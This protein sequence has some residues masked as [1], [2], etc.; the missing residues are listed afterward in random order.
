MATFIP[1]LTDVVPAPLLYQPDLQFALQAGMFANQQYNAALQQMSKIYGKYAAAPILNPEVDN[2]RKEYIDSL[3]KYIDKFKGVDLRNP[4]AISAFY[5]LFEPIAKDTEVMNGLRVTETYYQEKARIGVFKSRIGVVEGD[6]DKDGIKDYRIYNPEIEKYYDN[7][8][9]FYSQLKTGDPLL[10]S[11]SIKRGLVDIDHIKMTNDLF[12]DYLKA[13]GEKGAGGVETMIIDANGVIHNINEVKPGMVNRP[14]VVSA[15]GSVSTTI[16][17]QPVSQPQTGSPTSASSSAPIA[18]SGSSSASATAY[19][20]FAAYAVKTLGGEKQVIPLYKYFSDMVAQN[21]E[22]IEA[23]KNVMEAKIWNIFASTGFDPGKTMNIIH[24]QIIPPYI[25]GLYNLRKKYDAITYAIAS[26]EERLANDITEKIKAEHV[27]S[28]ISSALGIVELNQAI[29]KLEQMKKA[30]N[31]TK[32]SI[33]F[34]D[35]QIDKLNNLKKT[36]ITHTPISREAFINGISNLAEHIGMLSLDYDMMRFAESAAMNI[37]EQSV[38]SLGSSIGKVGPIHPPGIGAGG[39]LSGLANKP[40]P[41]TKTVQSYVFEN[42]NQ[43]KP[44]DLTFT[45]YI[46]NDPSK[47]KVDLNV[48]SNKV[49]EEISSQFQKVGKQLIEFKPTNPA[50]YNILHKINDH[51]RQKANMYS[52]LNKNLTGSVDASNEKG[53]YTNV[54]DVYL[55]NENNENKISDKPT[56]EH[57]IAILAQHSSGNPEPQI[58]IYKVQQIPNSTKSN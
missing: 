26:E 48:A 33:Q 16:S 6:K 36:G 46:P 25:E 58:K 9:L 39:G 19:P 56:N 18:V 37:Y 13:H 55:N 41:V 28:I 54:I 24:N 2:R 43:Y 4:D 3:N 23:K 12:F 38:V 8:A 47:D 30:N 21:P 15:S 22:V 57:Y 14:V 44:L 51:A 20:G 49:Y 52:T 45:S 32:E 40:I 35:Q 10:K 29:D 50:E 53:V 27:D 42:E 7:A 5:T 34:I 31:L 17:P 11:F 1:N